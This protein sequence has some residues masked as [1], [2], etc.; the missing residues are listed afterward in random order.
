MTF[1][2]ASPTTSAA[3]RPVHR[4]IGSTGRPTS[5]CV[6]SACP[7]PHQA[8][9]PPRSS[10]SGWGS[11]HRNSSSC[12]RTSLRSPR[13]G[14]PVGP[15]PVGRTLRRTRL[16]CTRGTGLPAR[17]PTAVSVSCTTGTAPERSGSPSKSSPGAP[18]PIPA[19]RRPPSPGRTGCTDGSMPRW[20]SGRPRSSGRRSPSA[21]NSRP[22]ASK[23][24][25]A[26]AHAIIE[27]M[28]TEPQN[29][30]LGFMLLFT[31][32]TDDWDSG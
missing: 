20:S 32:A 24:D 29:N 11:R 14:V 10:S 19:R 4:T 6:S 2:A 16:A 26:E 12:H 15:F 5:P 3:R 18:F 30:R 9:M 21:W 8:G 23:A 25:L 28:R 7:T 13:R 17:R 1:A 22:G 27:S 31:L